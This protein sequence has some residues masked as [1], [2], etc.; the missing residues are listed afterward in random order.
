VANICTNLLYI[1][2]NDEGGELFLKELESNFKVRNINKWDDIIECEIDSKWT[3][4]LDELNRII[5]PIE[6]KGY[7]IEYLRVFSY[8]LADYYHAINIYEDG[9]WIEY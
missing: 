7:N 8:D 4:P 5:Y 6:A 2:S 9:N 3:A 1:Q